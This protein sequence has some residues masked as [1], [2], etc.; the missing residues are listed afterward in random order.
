MH[1]I[2]KTVNLIAWVIVVYLILL[3]HLFFFNLRFLIR[4]VDTNPRV[5]RFMA[6]NWW[7]QE[8]L[9]FTYLSAL[10]NTEHSFLFVC[11]R[12]MNFW[13]INDWISECHHSCFPYVLIVI[14][15][16]PYIYRTIYLP[17]DNIRAVTAESGHTCRCYSDPW[18][19]AAK[20]SVKNHN[21]SNPIIKIKCSC[22]G[23]HQCL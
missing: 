2:D 16:K 4:A 13:N 11:G 23:I 20:L 15:R 14:N 10:N 17:K 21:K 18:D 6:R 9:L 22:C 5:H 12:F 7:R 1:F 19:L 8:Q 3:L